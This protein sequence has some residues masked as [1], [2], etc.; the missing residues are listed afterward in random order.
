MAGAKEKTVA[1]NANEAAL[2]EFEEGVRRSIRQADAGLVRSFKTKEEF[3]N[4]LKDL[5]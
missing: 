1:L 5:E 2:K 4:H 3:L